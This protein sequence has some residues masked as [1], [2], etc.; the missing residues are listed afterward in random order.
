MPGTSWR[1]TEYR[2]FNFV[3]L[4]HSSTSEPI[5]GTRSSEH[6]DDYKN[7]T[8]RE[9]KESRARRGKEAP[10]HGRDKQAELFNAAMQ[11]WKDQDMQKADK[12]GEVEKEEDEEEA[13]ARVLTKDS[14]SANTM[15]GG[16][17]A[18]DRRE[19][20]TTDAVAKERSKS[21]SVRVAA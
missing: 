10:Q 4:N 14:E 11:G 12:N 15:V 19:E 21:L 1:N 17:S 5:K 2:S 20:S 3:D 9:T 8:L 18:T 16:A 6:L 7:A 13:L